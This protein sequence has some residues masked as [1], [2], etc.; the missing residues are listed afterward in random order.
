[1]LSASALP[2]WAADHTLVRDLRDSIMAQAD[3]FRQSGGDWVLELAD[4]ERLHSE[5]RILHLETRIELDDSGHLKGRTL[6]LAG[7]PMDTPLLIDWPGGTRLEAMFVDGRP[8][9][10][11]QPNGETL[12]VPAEAV[13]V[14]RRITLIW[15]REDA[16]NPLLAGRVAATFPMPILGPVK[17]Q[18]SGGSERSA[19]RPPASDHK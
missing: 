4:K 3:V 12:E 7:L 19:S 8:V 15:S 9:A 17:S 2:E 16:G 5:P 6:L 14:V 10:S 18:V 11:S 1:M 13:A